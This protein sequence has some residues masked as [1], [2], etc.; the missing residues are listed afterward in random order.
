MRIAIITTSRIPSSTANSIQVMKVCQAYC[1]LGHNITLI[2]PGRGEVDWESITKIYGINCKFPIKYLPSFK[3]FRRFDFS[4]FSGISLLLKKYDLVHTWLPHIGIVAGVLKIPYLMELHELPTGKFGPG[5]FKRI[6]LSK[7][8]K[9]FLCI[10]NAL[11]KFYEQKYKFKFRKEEV[12]IA[13]MGVVLE[14]YQHLENLS[15]LKQKLGKVN[16]FT[17]V[18]TG[19][20]Y[21]GRGM[22]L[23][24]SL[25]KELPEIFFLWVGGRL[26]DVNFWKNEIQSQNIKNIKLT[27]FVNNEEIPGYQTIGDVLLMP[28]ENNISGSS[29]GNTVDYCSPMKMFEYMAAGR[30]I[31]SSDLP[32]IHEVLNEKNA[33]LCK[34]NDIQCW[35]DALNMIKNNPEVGKNLGSQARKDVEKYTWN[36]RTT[37]ALEGFIE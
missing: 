12:V 34:F 17:A 4:L 22:N 6:L 16:R 14:P 20:L 36:K 29:G 23:L 31:I 5:I 7:S 26:D 15:E 18:Y 10:T 3:L 28:Y 8:K 25:A 27:G 9:R 19:H 21:P 11:K 13:P 37:Q 35:T 30:P 33:I 1:Q 2:V 24:V 32:V